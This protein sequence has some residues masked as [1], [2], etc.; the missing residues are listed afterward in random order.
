M[1]ENELH[2]AIDT[3]LLAGKAVLKHYAGELIAEEKIGFDN[4]SEPVTIADREASSIIV[5]RLA[6]AFPNDGILSEEEIDDPELRL[7]K[8][9]VWII[10]PIDGTAGFIKKDGDFGVQIG[11]AEDGI[12]VL[13]VVYLPFHEKLC[14]AA[15]GEGSFTVDGGGSAVQM[16]TSNA[17]SASEMTLAMSRN[18]PSSRM[19]RIIEHFAFHRSIRRGSVGL[20]ISL[21]ADK[22]CDIYIHPSPR[23]KL[24]DTC[25]PQII[26]EE[27]GGRFTDLFGRE[28]SYDRSDLQN[29]NG[30][31]ASNGAAHE[32]IVE[33]LQPLLREFGRVPHP[34]L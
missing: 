28:M 20:K 33:Q 27:A 29:H 34:S 2:T 17:S 19:S 26:L 24:W 10:D 11:L 4:Y 13:G 22:T 1:L 8:R 23:T 25:A 31:V 3:A 5:E 6:A 15:K 30:I 7:A 9:R 18:H 16:K 14:Y 21:I 12:P 32:L